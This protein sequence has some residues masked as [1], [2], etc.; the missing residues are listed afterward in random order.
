MENTFLPK[1]NKHNT[2]NKIQMYHE[3]RIIVQKIITGLR[4]VPV[5]M[6]E[7][8]NNWVWTRRGKLSDLQTTTNDIQRITGGLCDA[9]S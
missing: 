5:H 2:N 3:R 4:S 6:Y 8:A 7:D 1:S 9:A